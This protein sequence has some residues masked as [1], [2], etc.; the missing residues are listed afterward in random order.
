LR[1]QSPVAPVPVPAPSAEAE[2]AAMAAAKKAVGAS[3]AKLDQ[4]T[5]E[6]AAARAEITALQRRVAEAQQAM[7]AAPKEQPEAAVSGGTRMLVNSLTQ[8]MEVIASLSQ[9]LR[10]PMSSIVG[11]SGLLMGE[12]VGILGALQRKF[13]ERIKASTERMGS[14]LDDLIRVTAL[15]SGK[16]ELIREALDVVKVV[17]DAILSVGAQFREKGINLQLNIADDIPAVTADRDAV[18]QVLGHLLN[19]AGS[20]SAI[21]GAVTLTVQRETDQPRGGDPLQYLF[22]SVRDTGG[23]IAPEDQPRVFSRLY[24]ADAPLIA[25]LGDTGVGLSIAKALVEAHAGRI[26]VNSE[27]GQGSTFCV[28]LPLDSAPANIPGGN[29]AH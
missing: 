3:Q 1:E 7:D 18:R 21:D 5:A 29:G 28:L 2:N 14:L 20:A 19:N 24:R 17:E 25:G 23:G 10:Q 13:L 11:Y 26:W 12:S 27:M 15:D 8:S 9:E 16:L 22:I 6:L 4:R